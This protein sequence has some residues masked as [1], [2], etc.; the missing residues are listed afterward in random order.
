[1]MGMESTRGKASR[2]ARGLARVCSVGRLHRGL[3]NPQGHRHLQSM[4]CRE[5]NM[6]LQYFYQHVSP[7][8]VSQS[9]VEDV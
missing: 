4:Q 9:L 6:W 1:M 7:S 2:Q 3:Q 5:F 8:A